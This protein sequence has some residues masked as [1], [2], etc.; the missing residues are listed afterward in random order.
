[1]ASAR[2]LNLIDEIS[3]DVYPNGKNVKELADFVQSLLI[4]SI[5][6]QSN[7][8][9]KLQSMDM[10]DMI[11]NKAKVQSL[12]FVIHILK[13]RKN[14]IEQLDVKFKGTKR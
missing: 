4:S 6:E 3:F 12:D 2:E 10:N 1:M 14:E 11:S 9:G 5:Y 8:N 7:S 13:L